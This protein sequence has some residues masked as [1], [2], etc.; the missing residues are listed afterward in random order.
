[1]PAV[2]KEEKYEMILLVRA[3]EQALSFYGEDYLLENPGILIVEAEFLR[4]LDIFVSSSKR[5]LLQ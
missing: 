4:N 3:F 2:N 5:K 1:M